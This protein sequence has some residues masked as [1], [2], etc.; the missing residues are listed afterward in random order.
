[1]EEKYKFKVKIINK[2]REKDLVK[3]W[4]NAIKE[5][6]IDIMEDYFDFSCNLNIVIKNLNK[7]K[8][9]V[10]GEVVNGYCRKNMSKNDYT[11]AL[12]INSLKLIRYD[13]GLDIYSTY[14][15]E[16]THIYDIHHI[17]NNKYYS[18]N[19]Q[20]IKHKTF[21]S[22]FIYYGWLYWTEF[23]AYYNTYKFENDQT[24][25]RLKQLITSWKKLENEYTQ[26]IDNLENQTKN[27]GKQ[28]FKD[29]VTKVEQFT[30]IFAKYNAGCCFNYSNYQYCEKTKNT[31]EYKYIVKLR[32]G[33]LKHTEKLLTNTYG[34]GLARKLY[35]LGYYIY[36]NIYDHFNIWPCKY[37]G[38]IKQ[39]V[40]LK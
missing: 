39:G 40:Y 26:I 1:M 11:I 23:Y 10:T 24:Y 25:P 33:L 32:K 19:P 4:G 6:A 14:I 35:N 37:W 22:F 29:F 2:T 31:K 18:I 17:I 16:L 5:L 20:S 8:N 38:S 9:F 13:E 7:D 12:N 36:V 15:H 21:S 3:L 30:Y 34:K 27:I 28:K